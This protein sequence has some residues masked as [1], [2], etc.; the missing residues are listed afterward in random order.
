MSNETKDE[1]ISYK[2]M[3]I[4]LKK[5]LASEVLEWEGL[6]Y[7]RINQF[8]EVLAKMNAL[9]NKSCFKEIYIGRIDK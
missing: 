3:W 7:P 2:N 1:E 9:E 5:D 8:R 6:E 4:N